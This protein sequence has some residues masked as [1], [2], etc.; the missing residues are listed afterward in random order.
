MWRAPE[1]GAAFDT[2]S[3][4]MAA[5]APAFGM[6]RE[7]EEISGADA[8][9]ERAGVEIA[10]ILFCKPAF[11]KREDNRVFPV[12]MTAAALEEAAQHEAQHFGF[13]HMPAR[14]RLLKLVGGVVGEAFIPGMLA[15]YLDEHGLGQLAGPGALR[16]QGIKMSFLQRHMPLEAVTQAQDAGVRKF[17]VERFGQI[18][19]DLLQQVAQIEL[20]AMLSA[21]PGE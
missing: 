14:Q 20:R 6:G 1:P 19:G 11:G 10:N 2:A 18:V 8:V 21:N 7:I 17:P 13:L 4:A 15:P 5:A 3:R 12:N 9:L 16:E